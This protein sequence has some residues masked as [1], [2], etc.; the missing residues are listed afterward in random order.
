MYPEGKT[1]SCLL[2]IETF[3]HFPETLCASERFVDARET[4][5]SDFI[6]PPKP[7][8][9]QTAYFPA[10]DILQPAIT[11]ESFDIP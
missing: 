10:R 5:K 7:F 2:V 9:R 6:D 1:A 4:D 3:D 11:D 8:H